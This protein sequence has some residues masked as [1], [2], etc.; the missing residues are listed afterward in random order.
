MDSYSIY[1]QDPAPE[2]EPQ[3]RKWDRRKIKKITS[4]CAGVL[5]VLGLSGWLWS[6]RMPSPNASPKTIVQFIATERFASL[7]PDQQQPYLDALDKIPWSERRQVF[8]QA[9][10]NDEERHAAFENTMGRQFEKRMDEFFALPVGPQRDAYLDRIIDQ[11]EARRQ[12]AT[13]RQASTGGNATANISGQHG[14]R[15]HWGGGNNPARMKNRIERSSPEMRT[16]FAEFHAALRAR[17][18]Q[19]GLQ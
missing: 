6:R 19:R 16:K 2:P 11:M 8:Q 1:T 12:R 10:L 14:G 17:R 4:I 15:G 13:T 3:K 18:A 7:P 5:V 9:N